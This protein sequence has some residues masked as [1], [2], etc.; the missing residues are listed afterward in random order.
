MIIHKTG[1]IK[2][3]PGV[4]IVGFPTQPCIPLASP[5]SLT[6]P[7]PFRRACSG[8]NSTW[9]V[10]LDMGGSLRRVLFRP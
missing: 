3:A 1:R 4:A 5:M 8:W 6:V 10:T 2:F 7:H 9:A